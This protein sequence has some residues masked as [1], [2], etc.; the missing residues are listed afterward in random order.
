MRHEVQKNLRNLRK[1]HNLH[2]YLLKNMKSRHR[3]AKGQPCRPRLLHTYVFRN[4]CHR[5]TWKHKGFP[6]A[7]NQSGD[8]RPLQVRQEIISSGLI[9]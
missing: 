4:P 2:V 5:L 7:H 8:Y 6:E 1:I 9:L 3:Y